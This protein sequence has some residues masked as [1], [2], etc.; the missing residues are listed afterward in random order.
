MWGLIIV[1]L[2]G[3]LIVLGNYADE[4]NVISFSYICTINLYLTYKINFFKNIHIPLYLIL[5]LICIPSFI[6]WYVFITNNYFLE[7]EPSNY[8]TVVF[9]MFLYFY[10]FIYLLS[11]FSK[12]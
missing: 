5:I 2:W 3:I 12:S 6:M 7:I 8:L 4:I 1:L 10:G 9:I 11:E